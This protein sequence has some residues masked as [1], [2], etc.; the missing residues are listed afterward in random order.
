VLTPR[1][2]FGRWWAARQGRLFNTYQP[3][4]ELASS[5]VSPW[6]A[7]TELQATA[8]AVFQAQ[9][10]VTV[11]AHPDRTGRFLAKLF[12]TLNLILTELARSL[13]QVHDAL[14]SAAGGGLPTAPLTPVA[15]DNAARRLASLYEYACAT[16]Q[17]RGPASHG[18]H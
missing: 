5:L 4:R 16:L 11:A 8:S 18:Q 6:L 2:P 10:A 12:D 7:P 3:P 14:P 15:L 1:W 9:L 13:K 17:V